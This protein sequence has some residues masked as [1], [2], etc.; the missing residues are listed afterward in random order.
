MFFFQTEDEFPYGNDSGVLAIFFGL[1][2]DGA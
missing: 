1:L 2:A